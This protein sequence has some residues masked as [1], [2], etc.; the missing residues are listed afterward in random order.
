[1]TDA[2]K[3]LLG[4]LAAGA[5]ML[6]V[7]AA[8]FR[9]P[10][11]APAAPPRRMA[12]VTR[13]GGVQVVEG[14]SGGTPLTVQQALDGGL[15]L[16]GYTSDAGAVQLSDAGAVL[17][18]G[19]DVCADD[20]NASAIYCAADSAVNGTTGSAHKGVP[21]S[22]TV[23]LCRLFPVGSP[24]AVYCAPNSSALPFIAHCY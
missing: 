6:L 4:A 13:A 20:G 11:Q 18:T 24:T 10:E 22:P 19:C 7:M 17:Y 12:E 15:D 16:G 8:P 2:K 3:L 1:M 5:V 23:Q 9:A 14:V 21:L